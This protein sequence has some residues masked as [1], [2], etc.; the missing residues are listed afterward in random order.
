MKHEELAAGGWSKLSLLEQLGNV[1]SEVSRASRWRGKD[2]ALFRGAVERALELMDLTI[3]DSRWRH[4]LK[5][6]VR[7]REVL[8]DAAL[9]ANEYG[10][11]LEGLDRYFTQFALAARSR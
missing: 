6:I 7:A 4:R 2:D 3:Q 1:G 5:E 8:C 9:G 10:A 11:T